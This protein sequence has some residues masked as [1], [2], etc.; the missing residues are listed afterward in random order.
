MNSN[1]A[2]QTYA[3][4]KI[5]ST[6]GDASPTQLIT[7]LL[8]GAL[9]CMTS[10]K[11]A[12]NRSDFAGAGES[13]G[14]AMKIIDGLDVLLD[15]EAGGDIASNLSRLYEYMTTLLLQA[16]IRRDTQLIGEASALLGDI[17]QGWV[18]IP[19]DAASEIR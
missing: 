18:A 5:E 17:R 2:I 6:I 15:H 11:G 19:E 9:E 8:D 4:T 12:M 1:S 16:N 14:K 13:I 3:K 10:A 7:S